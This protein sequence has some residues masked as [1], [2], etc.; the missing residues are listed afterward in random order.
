MQERINVY[1]KI[2]KS[3]A[4]NLKYIFF[5][6]FLAAL[7]LCCCTQGFSSC[8]EQGLLFI[9]V[10]VLLIA[11]ASFVAKHRPQSVW[12]SV[13]VARGLSSCGSRGLERR[14]SS[15]GAQAQLLRGRWDL[16]GPG[17]EPLSPALAGGFLTTAPPGKSPRYILKQ[18]S[19]LRTHPNFNLNS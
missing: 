14:L 18:V 1:K 9:V 7:G 2:I 19:T 12:A 3:T 11:V 15:C 6:L 10:H 8:G 16:P 5:N 17:L 13:V 4:T